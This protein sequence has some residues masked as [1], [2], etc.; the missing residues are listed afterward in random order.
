MYHITAPLAFSLPC[1][2][3]FKSHFYFA[4]LITSSTMLVESL[5]APNKSQQ[6]MP[7]GI[8]PGDDTYIYVHLTH[9]NASTDDREIV[10]EE[11]EMRVIFKTQS[12]RH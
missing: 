2:I 5:V 10:C 9:N 12:S 8:P 1:S 11:A 3:I 4:N 7:D 6:M